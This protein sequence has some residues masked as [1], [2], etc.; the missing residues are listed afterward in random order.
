M[1]RGPTRRRL[2]RVTPSQPES[3]TTHTHNH[4][5]LAMNAAA[6]WICRRCLLRSSF[7]IRTSAFVRRQTTNASP[8]SV[9]PAVLKRA[10]AIA[11]EHAQLSQKLVDSF[12]TRTAKKVG[13]TTPIVT[14]L[15]EWERANEVCL[16]N[17]RRSTIPSNSRPHSP[18]PNSAA[19]STTTPPTE[20]SATSPP[21]T[22][23]TPPPSSPSP[24]KP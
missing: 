21:T 8:D 17:G 11:A 13:E 14:A 12:D 24:R 3:L 20:S 16:L 4:S 15:K 6:G 10:R 18:S 19:S 22:S 23:P 5:N 7:P 1:K 9:S 2:R